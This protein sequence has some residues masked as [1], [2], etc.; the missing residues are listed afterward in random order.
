MLSGELQNLE[1]IVRGVHLGALAMSFLLVMSAD[2]VAAK[3]AFRPLATR[4][5][6]R[7]HANHAAL[8]SGLIILWLSGVFLIWRA[9]AF[10]L[11]QF[12]PKLIA[13]VAVITILTCNAVVIGRLALPYFERN[14]GTIFG[15]F[16][17]AVRFS[18]GGCAALSSASW[19]C[20]FCLGA[21]PWLKTA[22][23]AEL[24]SF[25]W[26]IYA[27]CFAAASFV[28]VICPRNK[29]DGLPDISSPVFGSS[30]NPSQANIFPAE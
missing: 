7:L 17:F 2:L 12:S 15:D 18:L 29:A 9:T 30:R 8:T 16:S 10:D 28:A 22:S 3:S 20:A 5:F 13:K 14:Q 6:K 23:A 24:I 27:V 19:L 11:E 25:L 21:L 4:N 1:N 26:P